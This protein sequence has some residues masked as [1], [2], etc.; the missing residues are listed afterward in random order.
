MLILATGRRTDPADALT[1]PAGC[2]PVSH[3]RPA[4]GFTLLELLVVV[5]II[6]ILATMFTLSVGLIT[7]DHDASA[8]AQRLQALLREAS[9][10]AV[11]EGRE[12]G[13]RFHPEGYEFL[14]QDPDDGRW[15]P[16]RDDPVLRSR[17]LT[18]DLRL[19]LEIDGR[20]VTLR[21]SEPAEPKT[22][23]EQ[24]QAAGLQPQVYVFSSGD[25]DPPFV[26]RIHDRS[27]NSQAALSVAGDGSMELTDES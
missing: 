27:G 16:V 21:A 19:S 7:D 26:I 13:L 15:A 6:G 1:V 4:C 17:A 11:L 14:A 20:E 10:D 23:S 24:T 25:I 9:E 22:T 5:V 12:Y 3:A 2:R 8:E 18:E